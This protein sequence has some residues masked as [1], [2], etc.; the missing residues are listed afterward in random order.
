MGGGTIR[1]YTVTLNTTGSAG[2]ASDSQVTEFIHGWFLDAY[3]A[4]HASAPGATTDLTIGQT[5][6][7][8]KILTLTNN[9]T[10]GRYAPRQGL[11]TRAGAAITDSH[12]LIPVNGTLTVAIA[13]CDA[14]TAAAVVTIRVLTF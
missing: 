4:Y 11:V 5:G 9:A 6:H 8:D 14:L 1:T 13:Q 10:S 7:A 2:S 3:P 12:D